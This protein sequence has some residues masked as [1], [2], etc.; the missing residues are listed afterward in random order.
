MISKSADENQDG[1]RE[2]FLD[3]LA[4]DMEEHPERIRGVSPQLVERVRALG[5]NA[6]VDLDEPIEGEV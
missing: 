6:W 3:F 5:A 4:R 1:A 2:A